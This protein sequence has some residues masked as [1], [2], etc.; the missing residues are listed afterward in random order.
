LILGFFNDPPMRIKIYSFLAVVLFFVCTDVF[1]QIS[2]Y[3]FS[4]LDISNGLSHNQVNCIFKDS[5]GFMWFGTASGL[6][7][8]DGN[9]F[10]IFKHDADDKNS[11]LNDF[12]KNIYE[13]PDKKLW[14]LTSV[15]YCFYDP[16]TERFNSDMPSLLKSLKIPGQSVVAKIIQGR[17]G[18]FWFLCSHA[19]IYRYNATSGRTKRYH[20]SAISK[21][22]LYSNNAADIS[23]DVKEIFG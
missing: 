17:S 5:Q 14:I 15:G 7:R 10:K 21:P 6:N 1:G 19:G 3:R 18:D 4:Q 2:Q 13:G 23:A 16:E 12:I 8:Y 11:V 22:S 9:T 20:N